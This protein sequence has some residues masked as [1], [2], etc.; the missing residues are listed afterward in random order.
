MSKLLDLEQKTEKLGIKYRDK[1][2]YEVLSTPDISYAE[3]RKLHTLSDL[4]E[5]Y[6]DGG[7]FEATLDYGISLALSPFR[8]FC[9]LSE[10]IEEKDGRSIRKIGQND[11]YR[12]IYAFIA[13]L[14]GCDFK[15]LDSAIHGDYSKN[16][17]R[18]A[19]AYWQKEVKK[20]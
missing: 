4:L 18:R 6:R 7:A 3:L 11:A 19:P 8:F 2:P 10:F 17:V 13:S 20:K 14:E 9:L 5:R 12:L 15:I 16:E 1:A